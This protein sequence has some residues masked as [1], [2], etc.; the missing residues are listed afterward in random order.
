MEEYNEKVFQNLKTLLLHGN[1]RGFG[2]SLTD[3]YSNLKCECFIKK[4]DE[5]IKQSLVQIIERMY[6]DV[7]ESGRF[8]GIHAAH[9]YQRGVV[10]LWNHQEKIAYEYFTKAIAK[11]CHNDLLYSLRATIDPLINP[12]YLEDAKWAVL[13]KPSPINYSVLANAMTKEDKWSNELIS[14]FLDK[15]IEYEPSCGC[16]YLMR[17]KLYVKQGKVSKA[18]EVFKKGLAFDPNN[19]DIIHELPILLYSVG[20]Y[21]ESIEYAKIILNRNADNYRFYLILADNYRRLDKYDKTCHYLEYYL[22]VVPH[23]EGNINDIEIAKSHLGVIYYQYANECYIYERYNEAIKYFEL[24]FVYGNYSNYI[25]PPNYFCALLKN[26]N[27]EITI[28]EENIHY[29]KLYELLC[30]LRNS[31]KKSIKYK[32]GSDS[33][34]NMRI[35]EPDDFIVFGKHFGKEISTILLEDPNYL[36]ASI[37]KK[38]HFAVNLNLFINKQFKGLPDYYKALE[39]NLIKYLLIDKFNLDGGY[40]YREKEY[41]EIDMVRE[42]EGDWGGLYGDEAETGYWNTD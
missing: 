40:E 37:I 7:S 34:Y 17:G 35:Y 1:I 33:V 6:P 13:I 23:N 39:I 25:Y 24:S 8:K 19:F 3:L 10:Y 2:E 28:G 27:K 14:K 20:E 16:L 9:S 30:T 12:N 4:Q 15:A 36:L 41:T 18:L 21:I 11:S 22:K 38:N 32:K 31:S 26:Y 5:S 29:V 42:M